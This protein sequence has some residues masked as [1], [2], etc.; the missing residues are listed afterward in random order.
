[1]NQG[2]K[3]IAR[4]KRVLDYAEACGNVNKACRHFG[5][6][7]SGSTLTAAMLLGLE[8]KEAE[9]YSFLLGLPAVALAGLKELYTLYRVHLWADDWS[10]L[11][12]S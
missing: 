7:R 5:V 1:M 4:K 3:D 2:Q 8:R 6:S 12:A 10:I 11:A 9:R